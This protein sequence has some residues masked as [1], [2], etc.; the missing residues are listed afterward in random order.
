VTADTF[1]KV[2]GPVLVNDVGILTLAFSP[3]GQVLAIGEADGRVSLWSVPSC[4]FLDKLPYRH[5]LG[6]L[7]V[8]FS[9]NGRLL[10]T[11]G[12]DSRIFLWDR[13][14][15]RRLDVLETP[16]GFVE[17]LVFTLDDRTLIA[18]NWVNS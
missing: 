5:E 2:G 11:G 16:Y 10:A 12:I 1:E 4:E 15:R 6:V 17:S 14:S 8:A 7:F 18:G 13:E 3:N 9:N